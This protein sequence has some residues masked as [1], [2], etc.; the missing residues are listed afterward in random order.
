MVVMDF[1]MVKIGLYFKS[2]FEMNFF[3][4]LKKIVKNEHVLKKII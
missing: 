2:S 3:L 1:W 4:F